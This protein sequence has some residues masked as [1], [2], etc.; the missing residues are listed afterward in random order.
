ME[1]AQA[2]TAM[3]SQLENAHATINGLRNELATVHQGSRKPKQRK[4][5][6]FRGSESDSIVSWV[7]HMSNYIVNTSEEDSLS[8][9]TSYLE[10]NA[11]EWWIAYQK[12][13]EGQQVRTWSSLRE[14]LIRRFETL[15]KS[16][17]AR[18]KLATWKQLKDVGSFNF[19]FQRIILDIP[20]ISMDEQLDRYTRGLKSYIWREM[21][22]RNYT[23][24][25]DAMRDAE[26]IE[27][28]HKRIRPRELSTDRPDEV[29]PMDIGNVQL[30]KLT[31]EEREKCMREGLCLRCR[32]K[33]HI[34]RNC[35]KGQ[36]N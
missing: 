3:Q 8:V 32:Q 5:D 17:I 24:L 15:N 10:G 13:V 28:A 16:K 7:T 19:H 26:R 2:V 1:L 21:C 18:D 14:A 22:T 20:D 33:G 36:R 31:P 23:S 11:H 27:A 4:P 25:L 6:P 9:A 30:K 35:P 34:A 12:T 29:V